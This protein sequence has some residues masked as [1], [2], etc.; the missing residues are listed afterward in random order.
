MF[1]L[2][3]PDLSGMRELRQRSAVPSEAL[4]ILGQTGYCIC[5]VMRR[6]QPL[7]DHL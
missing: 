5:A 1:L 3:D 4:K 7:G 6:T 2:N